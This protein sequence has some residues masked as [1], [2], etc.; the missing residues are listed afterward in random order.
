MLPAPENVALAGEPKIDGCGE[1]EGLHAS[2]VLHGRGLGVGGA[3]HG[4]AVVHTCAS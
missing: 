1:G 4:E 3:R 2:P